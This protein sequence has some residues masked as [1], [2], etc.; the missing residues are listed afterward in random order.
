MKVDL[1]L[2]RERGRDLSHQE[3]QLMPRYRGELR[4][5]E[6][7]SA[8][9]GRIALVAELISTTDGTKGGQLPVLRDATLLFLKD[10]QMRIAGI[11]AIEAV[12][13]AQTW[14]VRL[15]P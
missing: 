3:R 13:Y 8:R 5:S 6:A 2:I 15:E 12:Q 4:I 11:E 1:Q 14:D 10:R 9:L 7:R